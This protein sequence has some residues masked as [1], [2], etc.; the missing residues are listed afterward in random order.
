MQGH[1][2]DAPSGRGGLR[3]YRTNA[4]AS[5]ATVGVEVFGPAGGAPLNNAATTAISL[6][7]GATV[8]FATQGA[9]GLSIDANLATGTVYKGSARIVA[10]LPLSEKLREI[11]ET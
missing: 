3:S 5:S 9:A 8:M 6:A 7:T 2:G 1:S 11:G 10:S 4:G